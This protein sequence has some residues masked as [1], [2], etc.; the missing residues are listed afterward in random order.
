MNVISPPPAVLLL[1]GLNKSTNIDALPW[2][3]DRSGLGQDLGT[4]REAF[5]APVT[6]SRRSWAITDRV[7]CVE[8][9]AVVILHW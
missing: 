4:A 8:E 1:M 3:I 5:L 2:Y 6:A 7:R 9:Y